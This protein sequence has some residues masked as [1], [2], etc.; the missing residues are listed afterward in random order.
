M[1]EKF[2]SSIKLH[3]QPGCVN[4]TELDIKKACRSSK[5]II[6]PSK[7]LQLGVAG[8]RISPSTETSAITSIE[9]LQ[10]EIETLKDRLDKPVIKVS[11]VA[12]AYVNKVICFSKVNRGV[13]IVGNICINIC[14]VKINRGFNSDN[15]SHKTVRVKSVRSTFYS[16]LRSMM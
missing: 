3:L 14:I 6:Q 1:S 4:T 8:G 2:Q 7:H 9:F 15:C 11:K 16:T 12:E 5:S 10:K 13:H